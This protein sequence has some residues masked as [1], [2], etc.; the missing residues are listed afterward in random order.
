MKLLEAS[1]RNN[2]RSSG[3]KVAGLLK[4]NINQIK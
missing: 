4:I 2:S 3:R 1:E